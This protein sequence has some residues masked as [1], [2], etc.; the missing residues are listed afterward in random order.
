MFAVQAPCG[1]PCVDCGGTLGV[2]GLE[3]HQGPAPGAASANGQR[4]AT[5]VTGGWGTR[6]TLTHGMSLDLLPSRS[7]QRWE[8]CLWAVDVVADGKAQDE[9]LEVTWPRTCACA[10]Q[11]FVRWSLAS[12]TETASGRPITCPTR[13]QCPGGSAAS[14]IRQPGNSVNWRGSDRPC[15]PRLFLACPPQIFASSCLAH[16]G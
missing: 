9:Y 5:A 14:A 4:A 1:A 7:L 10:Q 3:L 12:V 11:Q 13:Q 6:P 16:H 15:N 2:Q 8:A